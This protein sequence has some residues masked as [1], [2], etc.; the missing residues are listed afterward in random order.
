MEYRLSKLKNGVR[1]ASIEMP[2]MRSVSVGIWAG[3]GARHEP[4]PKSGAAHF[5]EHLL[6]KGT[7]QRSPREIAEAVE[8]VG[9]YLNAFTSEE[10][11]CYFGKIGAAHFAR[12]C[13]VLTDMYLHSEFPPEE[14]ER[15]RQVIC[16]EISMYRDQPDQ[17]AQ[18]LLTET[19]WAG[20]ALGRSITGSHK[21]VSALSREQLFD[22]MRTHY[23]GRTTVVTVAGRI[24]HEEAVAELTPRLEK[25]SAG[26]TPRYSRWREKENT[27][28][29]ALFPHET[30]QTH[31]ALGF[32]SFGRDDERRYALKLLSVILGEN[33][34]SRLFQKLREQHG[35]C[36]SVSS[37]MSALSDSGA[38]SIYVG[39]DASNVKKALTMILHELEQLCSKPPAAGELRQAQDY[40]IGQTSMGLENTNCQMH[41][42]GESL[43][44]YGHIL[45]PEE[46]EK[47]FFTV[48]PE[49]ICEVAKPCL[50]RLR[51]QLAVVGPLKDE[52]QLA[53][54][55]A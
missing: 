7:K 35:F 47:Q 22:F 37:H 15:E 1:I 53:S 48:T 17:H 27:K 25:L 50:H 32:H 2:H 24:S 4:S 36:Y 26:K 34:S 29:I 9:G 45:D 19:M 44:G 8:G 14:V 55:L 5:I 43:L 12:L 10:H 28:R 49:Q 30:E 16:E 11:T 39:L 38:L 13:D 41:W 52:A 6:F 23:N 20:H 51:A 3:I 46:T 33:M 21:T 54:W 40:T 31:L 42:M 18:E